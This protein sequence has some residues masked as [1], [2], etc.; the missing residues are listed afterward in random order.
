MEGQDRQ[1]VRIDPP[2]S[3]IRRIQVNFNPKGGVKGMR[4]ITSSE[5]CVLSIGRFTAKGDKEIELQAGERILGIKS[6]LYSEKWGAI[7]NDLVFVVGR[8]E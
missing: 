6:R 4:F 7:H 3:K 5:K 2:N 1:T 8:M